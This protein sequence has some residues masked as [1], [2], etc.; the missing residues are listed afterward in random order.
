MYQFVGVSQTGVYDMEQAGLLE[1]LQ[2]LPVPARVVLD[3]HQFS[4]GLAESP[5]H[6]CRRV[7]GRCADVQCFGVAVLDYKVIQQPTVG[8]KVGGGNRLGRACRY[9]YEDATR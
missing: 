9:K 2:R 7:A 5:R 6:P 4:S 3:G 1:I 8:L